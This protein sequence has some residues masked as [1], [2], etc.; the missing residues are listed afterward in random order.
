MSL[1]SSAVSSL[2]LV[3]ASVFFF[4]FFFLS[5]AL[6]CWSLK[7]PSGHF[8]LSS[9]ILLDILNVENTVTDASKVLLW[10]ILPFGSVLIG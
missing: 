2:S 6:G 5:Q 4:F 1:L 7:V 8:F 10:L 9:P 3:P